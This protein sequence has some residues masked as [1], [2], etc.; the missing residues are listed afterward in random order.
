M[1]V[2]RAMVLPGI[3]PSVVLQVPVVDLPLTVLAGVMVQGDDA[4]G[5]E[6]VQRAQ[7]VIRAVVDQVNRAGPLCQVVLDAFSAHMALVLE[8]G[9]NQKLVRLP[10]SG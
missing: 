9:Q 4:R 8:Q 2:S 1:R 5:D 3:L 6:I 10:Q 7:E